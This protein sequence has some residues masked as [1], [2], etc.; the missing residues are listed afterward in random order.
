MTRK[1]K[2]VLTIEV[3]TELTGAELRNL[4]ALVFGR[5]RREA[6]KAETKQGKASRATIRREMPNWFGHDTRG[7]IKQVQ[8]NVVDRPSRKAKPL[9]VTAD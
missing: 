2:A 5:A 6:G 4:Q 8:V 7:I 9:V 1:R 3:E